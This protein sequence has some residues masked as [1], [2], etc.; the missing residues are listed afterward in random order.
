MCE[1]TENQLLGIL[2]KYIDLKVPAD[3]LTTASKLENIGVD[4]ISFMKVVV[5]I[6][7]TFDF[8]FRDEDLIID[9]FE[10]IGNV[11]HYID[12]RKTVNV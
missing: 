5:A 9:N 3:E 11:I 6:E 8:E 12:E 10:C 4:S 2:S 7:Q 1:S